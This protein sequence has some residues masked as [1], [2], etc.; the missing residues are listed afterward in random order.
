[1]RGFRTLQLCMRCAVNEAGL[2]V[3]V[4]GAGLQLFDGI[5]T[6]LFF[7][8]SVV[9]CGA[10]PPN[11]PHFFITTFSSVLRALH[12]DDREQCGLV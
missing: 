6:F 10:C 8:C 11:L 9:V 12:D 4:L 7:I 5:S 2:L 1:M 3:L